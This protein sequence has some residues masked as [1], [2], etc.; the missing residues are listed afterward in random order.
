MY[1]IV[2]PTQVWS[3]QIKNINIPNYEIYT[4]LNVRNMYLMC[5]RSTF[6][7]C[8]TSPAP[9][10]TIRDGYEWGRP[11]AE[12]GNQLL[13]FNDEPAWNNGRITAIQMRCGDA[14]LAFRVQY[15]GVWTNTRGFWHEGCS[16]NKTWTPVH[17][18]DADERIISA[19]VTNYAWPLSVTFTTNKRTLE[20]CGVPNAPRIK[21]ESGR[22]LEYFS[23]YYGCFFDRLQF[24]WS[25]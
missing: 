3:Q 7:T 8:S 10:V 5:L 17:T 6:H 14:F 2:K 22:R 15:N 20:T 24:Y 19:E 9:T 12:I 16:P 21:V 4:R 23:G 1:Y 11:P 18:F 25:D 13:Y